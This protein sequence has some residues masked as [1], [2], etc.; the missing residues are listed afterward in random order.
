MRSYLSF[1]IGNEIFAANVKNVINILE[2]TK[3][4][5]VPKSPAYMK[6]VINLRGSVLPVLDARL[7]FGL[8]ETAYTT[9]TCILVLDIEIKNES[10]LLGVIVDSVRE[11]IQL[12]DSDI[13]ASPSIGTSYNA[14][15]LW[16]MAKVQDE[17]VMLIDVNKVFSDE[18]V[19]N[20]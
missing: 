18:E 12:A 14:D 4:T 7:K 16:G 10:I 11:V 15:I 2:M 20:I 3:V 19:I 17:F 9:D 6:G 5:Q 1:Q 8:E 13:Q